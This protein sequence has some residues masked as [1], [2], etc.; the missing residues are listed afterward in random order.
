MYVTGTFHPDWNNDILNPAFSRLTAGDFEVVELGWRPPA[1]SL[2]VSDASAVEG[3]AGAQALEVTVTLSAPSDEPVTV[4][5]ETVD[6][7]AVSAP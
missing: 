4:D 6:G 1:P 3:D 7:T 5:F 2:S